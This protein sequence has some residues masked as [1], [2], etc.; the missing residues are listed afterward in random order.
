MYL[1]KEKIKQI[2]I[3]CYR[4]KGN[5]QNGDTLVR[6][7]TDAAIL[8]GAKVIGKTVKVYPIQGI[9]AVVFLAESHILISTY[10][11]IGYA[12]LEIFMCNENLSPEDCAE[13]IMAYLQPE[14]R[15]CFEMTHVIGKNP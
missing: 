13:L 9:T 8:T 11:E 2:N 4:C 14:K 5:L 7:I 6:A 10:P 1:K 15:I 3:D 12:V